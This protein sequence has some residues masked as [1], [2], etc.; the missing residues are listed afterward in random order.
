[1]LLLP[2]QV[3]RVARLF[4]FFSFFSF[5]LALWGVKSMR[6]NR[7]ILADLREVYRKYS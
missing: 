2:R 4:S 3:L 6:A 5:C 1:M 7:G